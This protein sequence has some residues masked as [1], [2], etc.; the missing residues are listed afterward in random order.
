MSVK[1]KLML[2]M[3]A[4]L[5]AAVIMF[6]AILHAAERRMLDRQFSQRQAAILSNI[7]HVARE[8]ALNSDPALL[9]NYV[10]HMRH[11]WDEVKLAYVTDGKSI[12]AHTDPALSPRILP[13]SDGNHRVSNIPESLL[14]KS[15]ISE[16]SPA[17]ITLLR[18]K[19]RIKNRNLEVVLGYSQARVTAQID[20]AVN[21]SMRR[22]AKAGALVL[23]AGTLLAMAFASRLIRPVRGLVLAFDRAGRGDLDF[24][25]EE[26]RRDEIGALSREFNRMTARLRELDEMKKDFT[27]SVTH[28]LK[29]PLGAIESYMDLM[30][31][32][33]SRCASDPAQLAK[34]APKLLENISFV[35]NNTRRLLRFISDLLDAAKIEKGKFEV[36][37][38]LSSI[39]PVIDG[40]VR[41]FGPRASESGVSLE[42]AREPGALPQGLLD[43][44]RL[45]QVLANLVSNA[46]KF[47]PKGGKVTVRAASRAAA[48]G[49]KSIRVSVEDT[50]IG[51]KP[52][53][54]ARLFEKFSQ[55]PGSREK[56]SG[57]K[58]TGL[59]LFITKSI[60]EAHGGKVFADSSD[61]GSVFGFELPAA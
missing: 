1:Y 40:V 29:S 16:T 48:D 49:K 53:D 59:G 26:S 61:E 25:L 5:L 44:D 45:S 3:D 22:I 31:Y 28:E 52:E 17:G 12:L 14:I 55:L 50:G 32:E 57:P 7:T 43:T 27:S 33:M 51:I 15:D 2:A 38:R 4:M 6:G 21:A 58:G 41:L 39:E 23:L 42:F 37:R 54:M 36:A 19:L 47:T 60:V 24:R 11:E 34:K 35:K 9:I 18:E 56:A 30:E 8:S 20:A 13:L 46:L 10:A